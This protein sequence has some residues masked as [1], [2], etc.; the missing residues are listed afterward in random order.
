MVS[1]NEKAQLR[2]SSRSETKEETETT[3]VPSG[4]PSFF[5]RLFG[6]SQW[7]TLQSRL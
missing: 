6:M 3:D 1:T 2:R 7:F 4:S 5:Q